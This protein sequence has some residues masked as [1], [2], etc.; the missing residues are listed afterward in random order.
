MVRHTSGSP[1]LAMKAEILEIANAPVK[2]AWLLPGFSLGQCGVKPHN[3]T[4]PEC[5][6]LGTPWG[7]GFLVAE[8]PRNV[9]LFQ[10]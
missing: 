4:Q 2:C 3:L 1:P 5:L 10:C 9:F 6:G 7:G 8:M